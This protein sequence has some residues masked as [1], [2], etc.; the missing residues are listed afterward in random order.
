MDSIELFP[1]KRPQIKKVFK[2]FQSMV[3]AATCCSS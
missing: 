1:Y 2:A 3:Q